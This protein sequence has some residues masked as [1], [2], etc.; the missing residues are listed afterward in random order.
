MGGLIL[1]RPWLLLLLLPWAA[2]TLWSLRHSRDA[3]GWQ[4]LIPPQMLRA[5]FALGALGGRQP[6]WQRVLV[7]AAMLA[8]I[9]GTS[10]PAM[11]RR[12]APVLA[13]TDAVVIAIDLSPSVAEGPGLKQAQ[14][15]A[16][17]LLQGL[18]GRPVGLIIY[19]G[20]AYTVA[21]P[22][23]DLATLETQIAVLEPDTMP[24]PGSRVADALGQAGKMLED[25]RRA[26]LVV[27]SD[28]GGVDAQAVAE[29]DRL[30]GA[31]VRISAM[32]ISDVAPEAPAPPQDALL[33]LVRGGGVV[34]ESD[35]TVQMTNGLNRAGVSV[36][37]PVLR[38][39]QYRDLGPL[40]AAFALFPLLIML[41]RQ[42]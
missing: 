35:Q 40:L 8:L 3:G 34:M 1:M 15:A 14:F 30:A 42:R 13:Q 11:P 22:T 26:D 7:P 20:E 23:S 10:G 36:R 29:A 38:A 32:R 12:D 28:G 37:D 41:R 9:L 21:A 5:M 6:M 31:G 17:G 16:A 18:A 39:L 25:P 33:R 2:L 24:N 19:G 4:R 27:I